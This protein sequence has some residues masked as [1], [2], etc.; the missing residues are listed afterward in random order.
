MAKPLKAAGNTVEE[1][2]GEV[3][4]GLRGVGRAF[5]KQAQAVEQA[6]DERIAAAVER[7]S[8]PV[9]TEISELKARIQEL[10]SKVENLQTRRER[11]EASQ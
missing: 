2:L 8:G 6:M 9:V 3:G 7:A 11:P 1:K 5:G 10:S 4:S